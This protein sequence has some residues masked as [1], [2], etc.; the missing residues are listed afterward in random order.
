MQ[1]MTASSV[2]CSL[3]IM[4]DLPLLVQYYV[5]P[6]DQ[7]QPVYSF[8]VVVNDGCQQV[9]SLTLHKSSN[10]ELLESI[11]NLKYLDTSSLV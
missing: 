5:S 7:L 6:L 4:K 11:S 1:L 2:T 10:L 3:H 9:H 8:E